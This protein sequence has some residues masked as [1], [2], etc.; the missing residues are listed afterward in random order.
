MGIGEDDKKI[1]NLIKDKKSVVLLNKSD[2]NGNAY[3]ALLEEI[4]KDTN[5]KVILTSAKKGEGFDELKKYIE[6]E[7]LSGR[8]KNNDDIYITN[9]RQLSNLK[10]ALNYIS[11]IE[12]SIEMGM[13]EDF[14]TIDI[15]GAYHSLSEITGEDISED[16]INRIF[17]KFCM[18]K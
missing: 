17:E 3:E 11:N 8:L 16:L 14:Y 2:L 6:E 4:R 12:K 18:G 10:E 7:F 15:M 1:F 13:S 9:E 5:S